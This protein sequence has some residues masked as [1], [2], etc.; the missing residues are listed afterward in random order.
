MVHG[1]IKVEETEKTSA[2]ALASADIVIGGVPVK[3][4]VLAAEGLKP[5]AICINVS[6]F[7]N[8]G[9]GTEARCALVPAV[10]KVTIAILARNLLRLHSNFHT[11]SPP[12]RAANRLT[13][14]A[15]SLAAVA[16]ILMLR[17]K[18]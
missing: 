11:L 17:G 15:I 4:F 18:N 16:A 13:V 10:G 12:P 2:A 1:T 14:A 7:M 9:E 6:Q 5:G 8:F 3:G